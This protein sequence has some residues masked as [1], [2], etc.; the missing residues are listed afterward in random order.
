MFH[1]LKSSR[2]GRLERRVRGT[3]ARLLT[4][5]PLSC[6]SG[7]QLGSIADTAAPRGERASLFPIGYPAFD[8]AMERV[9]G[10][11]SPNFNY[12][13]AV[14]SYQMM[15]WHGIALSD[16]SIGRAV[17]Y[18]LQA[19][20]IAGP[21]LLFG[22]GIRII[23]ILHEYDAFDNLFAASAVIRKEIGLGARAE[24]IWTFQGPTEIAS[25]LRVIASSRG[26]TTI[27]IYA[28]G[29]G[30]TIRLSDAVSLELAELAKILAR[31]GNAWLN[32][33]ADE[34]DGVVTYLPSELRR[35][36]AEIPS[37]VVSSTTRGGMAR[38][39]RLLNAISG[40]GTGTGPYV[41]DPRRL[42]FEDLARSQDFRA[43]LDANPG[44]KNTTR[45]SLAI[46]QRTYQCARRGGLP[47]LGVGACQEFGGQARPLGAY[48]AGTAGETFEIRS[49]GETRYSRF[50]SVLAHP[51]QPIHHG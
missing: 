49:C 27:Y 16:E 35:M 51:R 3:V 4:L 26:P 36:G 15:R 34:C 13:L 19:R 30:H 9:A 21:R 46:P 1:L 6:G 22:N 45:T 24:D 11:R 39:S 23:N 14:A 29:S 40:T 38:G 12:S 20:E 42:E 25:A 10:N 8:V 17:N 32:V 41:M 28:H 43:H 44:S 37:Y 31:R 5:L 48:V 33:L 7:T 47:C 50:P 18:V 2:L